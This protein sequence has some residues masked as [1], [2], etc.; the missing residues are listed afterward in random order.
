VNG[1]R[2]NR[3]LRLVNRHA[4]VAAASILV[5]QCSPAHAKKTATAPNQMRALLQ[6]SDAEDRELNRIRDGFL[7]KAKALGTVTDTMQQNLLAEAQPH[8]RKQVSI[9]SQ[10]M[11]AWVR[12]PNADDLNVISCLVD[13]LS[14]EVLAWTACMPG[15]SELC[16]LADRFDDRSHDWLAPGCPAGSIETGSLDQADLSFA[17]LHWVESHSVRHGIISLAA[18]QLKNVTAHTRALKSFAETKKNDAAR[19]T[20]AQLQRKYAGEA[21]YRGRKKELLGLVQAAIPNGKSAFDVWSD[22][23]DPV[24]AVK[25]VET[26]LCTL[27]CMSEYTDLGAGRSRRTDVLSAD[28]DHLRALGDSLFKRMTDLLDAERAQQQ[29]NHDAGPPG[30]TTSGQA[31]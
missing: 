13:R 12:H 3:P 10:M 20:S 17:S 21:A 8:L 1:N 23:I 2:S 11:S 5:L 25:F 30:G 14:V 27:R 26:R 31:E 15:A 9:E 22:A 28:T 18:A 4:L 19:L 24:T 16:S 7:Q 29:G 6:Q